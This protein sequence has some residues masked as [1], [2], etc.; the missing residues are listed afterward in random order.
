[1]PPGQAGRQPA[2]ADGCPA[3][4]PKSLALILVDTSVWIDHLRKSNTELAALLEN[5]QVL[6]HPFVVGELAC[7]HLVA[8]DDLL[9][10]LQQLPAA[11][12][13]EP[14][15]ALGFAHAAEISRC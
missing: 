14:D 15:E 2:R 12:V 3:A 7:G 10:L 13:A 9:R 1:M 11:A 4:A 8:R 6:V 5:G